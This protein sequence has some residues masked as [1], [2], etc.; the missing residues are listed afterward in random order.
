[1]GGWSVGGSH[2]GINF[3]IHVE[4]GS[5][6]AGVGSKVTFTQLVTK[7]WARDCN[8]QTWKSMLRSGVT[9]IMPFQDDECWEKLAATGVDLVAA[10][11]P[12]PPWSGLTA[13]QGLSSEAGR[14][15]DD[16]VGF[17]ECIQPRILA[18]ENVEGLIMHEHWRHIVGRFNDVGFVVVR[19]SVDKLESVCPMQRSRA[20]VIFVNVG[21]SMHSIDVYFQMFSYHSWCCI[22]ILC[23][24]GPFIP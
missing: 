17:V 14:L 10:S 15:F 16:L 12:C 9:I 7:D 5:D 19:Q 2:L 6:V 18:L 22:P 21:H 11:L 20:S 23:W 3:S 24:Q 13:Q 8:V 1:M 4:C